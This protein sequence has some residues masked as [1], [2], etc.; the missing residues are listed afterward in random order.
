MDRNCQ[1]LVIIR[2]ATETWHF[3]WCNEFDVVNQMGFEGTQ[4]FGIHA[5]PGQIVLV[6]R[7]AQCTNATISSL[8]IG[9]CDDAWRIASAIAA[10]VAANRLRRVGSARKEEIDGICATITCS[11]TARPGGASILWSDQTTAIDTDVRIMTSP[12][13]QN[14]ILQTFCS[15]RTAYLR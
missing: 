13:S 6:V 12:S 2:I 9:T 8:V 4:Q 3:V 1:H 7:R 11:P 10:R 14:L 15:Y 5:L